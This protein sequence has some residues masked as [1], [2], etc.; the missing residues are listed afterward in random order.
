M[1][2]VRPS[3]KERRKNSALP[4]TSPLSSSCP[5]L[6]LFNDYQAAGFP[7]ETR[8]TGQ[9]SSLFT[10]FCNQ[11]SSVGPTTEGEMD[12]PR[13]F[14]NTVY[15]TKIWRE[16]VKRCAN[17]QDAKLG[18]HIDNSHVQGQGAE[19]QQPCYDCPGEQSCPTTQGAEVDE[20][21]AGETAQ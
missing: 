15:F 3:C 12:V 8:K 5:F 6:S 9:H 7:W 20:G 1:E 11:T 19:G 21:P 10:R 17:T 2:G 16:P 13:T 18:V 14:P 4:Q